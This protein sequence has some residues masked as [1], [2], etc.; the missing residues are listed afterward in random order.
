MSCCNCNTVASSWS[1]FRLHHCQITWKLLV[2]LCLAHACSIYVHE[3]S[4]S[5]I[6]PSAATPAFVIIYEDQFVDKYF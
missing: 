6:K 5:I 3:F 1:D 2:N 4:R